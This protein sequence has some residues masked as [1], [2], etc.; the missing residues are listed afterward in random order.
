MNFATT[1]PELISKIALLA[2]TT[3]TSEWDQKRV[4]KLKNISIKIW[5]GTGDVN[6]GYVYTKNFINKV[7]SLGKDINF[8]TLDNKT[9][10]DVDTEYITDILDFFN[11]SEISLE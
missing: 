5:H 8:V 9:H 11:S 3:R 2:P 1:Y 7:E 10:W 6:V 4:D